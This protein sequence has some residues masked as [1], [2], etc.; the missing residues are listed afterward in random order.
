MGGPA[1]LC[2]LT[3][4]GRKEGFSF[5]P[6]VWACPQ[7]ILPSCFKHCLSLLFRR[8]L[9]LLRRGMLKRTSAV[10]THRTGSETRAQ[11]YT[12]MPTNLI[13][14][15]GGQTQ[16]RVIAQSPLTHSKAKLEK[17]PIPLAHHKSKS[18]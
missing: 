16:P 10:S 11:G 12:F 13:K 1:S 4:A 17:N 8:S 7:P 6:G 14:P 18:S 2:V 5:P 15:N 9:S 3:E